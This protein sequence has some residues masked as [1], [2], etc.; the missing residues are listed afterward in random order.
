MTST[1]PARMAEAARPA[2]NRPRTRE[3]ALPAERR[4][5]LDDAREARPPQ[6]ERAARR[7]VG[8]SQ[9][10]RTD[11]AAADR[12][13]RAETRS[14]PRATPAGQARSAVRPSADDRPPAPERPDETAKETDAPT[15]AAPPGSGAGAEAAAATAPKDE[16]AVESATEAAAVATPPVPPPAPAPGTPAPV[17]QTPAQA[18]TGDAGAPSPAT[19]RVA[20]M[21][22]GAPET[23]AAGTEAGPGGGPAATPPT[24][25][26][27][28]P[29][30]I[31]LRALADSNRFEIR[32]DP[33]HLGR[34][35]VSLDIDRERG[36]VKAHLV[37]E[38]P[39]TL[40]LLQ[41]DARSL[42]QALSQAGL[43]AGEAA[44]SFSLG[45]GSA[46]SRGGTGRDDDGS[47]AGS[48]PA[49]PEAEPLPAAAVARLG[50]RTGLDLV[51]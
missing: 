3:A 2:A 6:D 1:G 48:R 29:M 4:F 35:A 30:T 39:E 49:L 15:D 7:D 32:L 11:T 31:G 37:V 10:R 16:E 33:A 25:L 12:D 45:D 46:G 26:S 51:I 24:P 44:L 18:V 40:A 23:T 38:R 22:A 17:P 47:R 21:K 13:R 50:R 27:A 34:V 41:R 43:S 9:E 20:A 8:G 19:G 28:V 5:S 42:E 14:A 36:A